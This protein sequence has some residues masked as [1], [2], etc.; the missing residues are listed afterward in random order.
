MKT[1]FD[2]D[3]YWRAGNCPWT[4]FAYPTSLADDH[5]LPPDE[6]AKRLLVELRIRGIR[7]GIWANGIAN[8]TTYFACPKEEIQR[9]HDALVVLEADGSFEKGFCCK[10]TDYLF[11]LVAQDAESD[12]P[13]NLSP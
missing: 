5:G 6:D 9:L 4:F 2:A 3:A 8:D 10:R 7:V 12:D 11:S 13:G 1:N